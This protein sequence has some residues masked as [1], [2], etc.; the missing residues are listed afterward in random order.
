MDRWE[1]FRQCLIRT[2]EV[3]EQMEAAI[4]EAQTLLKSN[5]GPQALSALDAKYPLFFEVIFTMSLYPVVFDPGFGAIWFKEL[6]DL[7]AQTG[8]PAGLSKR[9]AK[10]STHL[11]PTDSLEFCKKARAGFEN[12]DERERDFYRTRLG[13]AIFRRARLALLLNCDTTFEQVRRLWP[14]IRMLQL[15]CYGAVARRKP[16]SD[17]KNEEAIRAHDLV[18]MQRFPVKEA[19][20][21]AGIPLRTFSRHLQKARRDI[22]AL[23]GTVSPE[24]LSRHVAACR[25]CRA[26]HTCD[27]M[28][29][30]FGLRSVGVGRATLLYEEWER[31]RV[32]R[33]RVGPRARPDDWDRNR[34]GTGRR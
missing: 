12:M 34:K 7:M 29:R 20:R 19:A 3:R 14:T 32:R 1:Y 23:A 27:S 9:G 11:A 21:R 26:G 13:P 10:P 16:G 8:P 2:P 4:R 24:W 33:G 22:Q 5:G 30:R 15:A 31:K 17:K 28:E 6:T 25:Q 18:E